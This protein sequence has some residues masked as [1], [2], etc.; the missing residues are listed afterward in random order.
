[1]GAH[2]KEVAGRDPHAEAHDELGQ[3]GEPQHGSREVHVLD[4]ARDEAREHAVGLPAHERAVD[5]HDQEGVEDARLAGQEAREHRLQQERHHDRERG[6]E[7]LH[8]TDWSRTR[9]SRALL[10]TSTSS[11]WSKRAE[12]S[13]RMSLKSPEPLFTERTRPTTSPLG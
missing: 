11:T 2:E 9:G 12:G 4:P 8:R 10:T 3:G 7:G 5:E 6:P 13:T 1:A